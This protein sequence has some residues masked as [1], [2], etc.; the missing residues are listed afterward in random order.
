VWCKLIC[1][2]VCVRVLR[3]CVFGMQVCTYRCITSYES[4]LLED[5]SLWQVPA[6]GR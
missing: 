5:F 3:V 1:M 4:P 6:Q 2:C